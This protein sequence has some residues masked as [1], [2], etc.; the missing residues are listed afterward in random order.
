[1]VC[2]KISKIFFFFSFVFIWSTK[3]LVEFDNLTIVNIFGF[4]S[5]SN[6][7]STESNSNVSLSYN[8]VRSCFRGSLKYNQVSLVVSLVW[9]SNYQTYLKNATQRDDQAFGHWDLPQIH[10]LVKNWVRWSSNLRLWAI[11]LLLLFKKMKIV[12]PFDLFLDWTSKF[13]FPSNLLS[14]YLLP[15]ALTIFAVKESENLIIVKFFGFV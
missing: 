8:K 13:L 15:L 2:F 3:H 5:W 11:K 10:L 9:F 1:M 6:I 12:Y 4:V 14:E 7:N